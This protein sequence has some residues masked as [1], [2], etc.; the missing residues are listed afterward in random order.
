MSKSSFLK[1]RANNFSSSIN[2]SKNKFEI[3]SKLKYNPYT[4][5]DQFKAEYQEKHRHYHK[6][7]A[8]FHNILY[9]GFRIGW[10]SGDRDSEHDSGRW[11]CNGTYPNKLASVLQRS[12]VFQSKWLMNLISK[13]DKSTV[14]EYNQAEIQP[15]ISTNSVFLYKDN[16]NYFV[17]RRG[18]ERLFLMFVL[19]QGVSPSGALMYLGIG[20][21]LALVVSKLI[22]YYFYYS[23]KKSLQLQRI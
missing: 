7:I 14:A 9:S 20:V 18:Y 16:S 19:A 15:Q 21:Y 3:S 11:N 22:Y 10:F 8:P 17:N 1:L 4:Q 2:P 6:Y 13:F 5:K 12:T 23:S